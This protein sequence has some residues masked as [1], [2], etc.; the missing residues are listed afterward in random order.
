M[1]AR[2]MLVLFVVAALVAGPAASALADAVQ[3]SQHTPLHPVASAP[4]RNGFVENIHANG[5]NVFAH[6]VYVV[7]GAQPNTTYDVSIAVY[8]RD[9]TCSSSSPLVFP[10]ATLTTSAGGGGKAD[11]F[12]TPEAADALR[13]ATHGA[14]WTLSVD[15]APVYRTACTAIVL[16]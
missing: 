5:P 7:A 15:G 11:V 12:F 4:L 16:D 14:I 2:Q 3:H 6:E 1:R 13:H 10:T 8:F 9:P